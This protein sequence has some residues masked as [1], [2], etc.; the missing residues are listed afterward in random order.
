LDRERADVAPWV[1]AEI[2]E[3]TYS[4]R[5]RLRAWEILVGKMETGWPPDGVYY[6]EEYVNNLVIR[7]NL[8]KIVQA[9]PAGLRS[10]LDEFL[11][12]L[13]VRFRRQTVDDGGAALRSWILPQ[14]DDRRLNW[15]W[16]RAPP[17]LVCAGTAGI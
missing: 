16:H 3:P 7:D 4:V 15:W 8:E 12:L 11:E 17:G 1:A 5:N 10:A 2:S 9:F 14:E 13:D 6:P